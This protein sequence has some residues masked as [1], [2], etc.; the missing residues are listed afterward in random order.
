MK[1][2]IFIIS[3]CVLLLSACSEKKVEQH[4]TETTQAV[5][6]QNQPLQ[7]Q[8]PFFRLKEYM[9]KQIAFLEGIMCRKWTN[10]VHLNIISLYDRYKFSCADFEK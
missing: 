4:K 7:P 8:R 10:F 6:S 5:Q 1:R 9:E 2:N 3:C